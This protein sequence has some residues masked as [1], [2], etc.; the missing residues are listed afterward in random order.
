LS[1]TAQTAPPLV[2]QASADG[3][4][5]A[6]TPDEAIAWRVDRENRGPLTYSVDARGR[7]LIDGRLRVDR[8]GEVI[9]R[10]GAS[11]G[12]GAMQHAGPQAPGWSAPVQIGNGDPFEYITPRPAVVDRSG[13]AWVILNGFAAG[14]PES[15]SEAILQATH[16]SGP[17]APWTAPETLYDIPTFSYVLFPP[18]VVIDADD[19][20][21]VADREILGLMDTV[22]VLRFVP[23][24]GWSGPMTIFS[25]DNLNHGF[26]SVYSVVDVQGNVVV[27]FDGDLGTAMYVIV[28]DAAS[29]TWGPATA[30]SPPP[31]SISV[32]STLIQNRS[33][34]YV[35]AL[36]QAYDSGG[37]GLYLR[38][39]RSATLDWAPPQRVPGDR[40][41]G[42]GP[43]TMWVTEHIRPPRVRTRPTGLCQESDVVGHD[44]SAVARP[45]S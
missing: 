37:N 15:E 26:Q 30:I 38:R 27:C 45:R 36:Y 2:L 41:P 9:E 4:V 32:L 35:Y 33:G 24:V 8:W 25:T 29:D 7:I 17:G 13:T 3:R 34:D 12:A 28:Y 40:T 23:S 44:C 14:V 43:H 18:A 11:V 10:A 39:F 1:A 6:R 20:I 22:R 19:H 31:P 16:T 21:T 5:I 42:S